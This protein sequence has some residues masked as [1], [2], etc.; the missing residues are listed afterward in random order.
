MHIA[1]LFIMTSLIIIN[2]SFYQSISKCNNKIGYN[3][4]VITSKK[5]NKEDPEKLLRRDTCYLNNDDKCKV[6][7]YNQCTN[8]IK[9]TNHCDCKEP[10]FELCSPNILPKRNSNIYDLRYLDNNR[11]NMYN[12]EHS[13]FNLTD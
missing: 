3:I 9:P 1:L 10:F 2:Y 12:S 13:S 4:V 8:N 5:D 11:V 7:S 6:G